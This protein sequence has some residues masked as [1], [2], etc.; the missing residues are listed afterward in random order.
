MA[1]G[2]KTD[3][4]GEFIRKYV[5]ILRK[6]PSQYIYEPWKAPLQVSYVTPL[7][8]QVQYGV[9]WRMEDVINHICLAVLVLLPIVLYYGHRIKG[10]R[11]VRSHEESFL[12]RT[13]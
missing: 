2:K 11:R 9:K 3:K 10:N 13:V 7:V 12:S 5:P 6:F 4:D 1:F 8:Y